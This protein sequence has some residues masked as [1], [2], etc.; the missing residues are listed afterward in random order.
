VVKIR[1][2][3]E[4]EEYWIFRKALTERK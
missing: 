4:I 2:K 3:G 1:R